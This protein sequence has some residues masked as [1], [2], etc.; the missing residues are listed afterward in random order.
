M[1]NEASSAALR[2]ALSEMKNV[3]PEITSTFIF[4][5]NGEIVAEDQT[6]TQ[7]T[8]T[9]HKKQYET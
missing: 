7:A 4:R 5:E 2:N 1:S 6:T 3:C 9:T 8:I